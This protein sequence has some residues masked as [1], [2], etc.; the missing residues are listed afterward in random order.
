M[1]L[2]SRKP[3]VDELAAKKDVKGLIEALEHKEPRVREQAALALGKIGHASSI[4]ALLKAQKDKDLS[5]RVAAAEALARVSFA[6]T[7]ET[8]KLLEALKHEEPSV[9][10][11]AIRTLGE[12]GQLQAQK[13]VTLALQDE[14]SLVRVAAAEALGNIL[15][16]PES[17]TEILKEKL[18]DHPLGKRPA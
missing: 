6:A 3:N 8:K 13:P 11:Q 12:M 10:E 1:G 9:R 18:K 7:P 4:Q 14:D 5:V 16:A 2:F 15:G 17:E